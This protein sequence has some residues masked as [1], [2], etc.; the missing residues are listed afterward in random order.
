[1]HDFLQCGKDT[2]YDIVHLLTAFDLKDV[3]KAETHGQMTAVI[4][5]N[6]PYTMASKGPFILSFALGHDVSLRSVLG[7]PTLLAMGTDM[8]LVKSFLSCSEFNREISLDLQPPGHGLPEG[9]S[10]NHYLSN[11]PTSV[12]TNQTHKIRSYIIQQQK[13]LRNLRVHVHLRTIYLLPII[14][15]TIMSH[16]NSNTFHLILTILLLLVSN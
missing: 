3:H 6:T 8:N 7:L 1:M 13:V 9:V 10:L 16:G 14:F 5:Y 15:L 12:S 11:V 2:A 4:L